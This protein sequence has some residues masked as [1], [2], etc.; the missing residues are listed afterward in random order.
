MAKGERSPQT[1]RLKVSCRTLPDASIAS[2]YFFD[3]STSRSKTA[4]CKGRVKRT[5]PV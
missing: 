1:E 3:A 2:R 4:S 5:P